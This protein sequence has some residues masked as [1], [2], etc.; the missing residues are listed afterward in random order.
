M[1]YDLLSRNT[2]K[3]T[4]SE[5]DMR[6]YS[7][8]AENIALR[9]AET[10]RSL[11]RMLRK[12]KLFSGYKPD[13]LFLEAF[14]ASDGGC[15]LYVS[16]LGEDY[17]GERPVEKALMCC[18]ESLGDLID[19]CHTLQ[20]ME[21]KAQTCVYKGKAGYILISLSQ[22]GESERIRRIFGEYGRVCVNPAEICIISEYAVPVCFTDACRRFS[23]LY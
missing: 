23:E 22:S 5:E 21:I 10:K 14:P 17:S 18:T 3:I 2:V 6:E 15:V 13:R 11:S 1:K 8:C 12:M 19:L 16:S 9:T 4:L 7:L 20:C